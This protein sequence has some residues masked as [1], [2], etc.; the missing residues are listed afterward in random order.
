MRHKIQILVSAFILVILAVPAMAFFEP[1]V[2]GI[3]SSCEG[4]TALYK[5]MELRGSV[6]CLIDRIDKAEQVRSEEIKKRRAEAKA[7]KA[8][9]SAGGKQ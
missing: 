7:K 4:Y 5:C 6:E 1:I 2:R 8:Q 3:F 9:K